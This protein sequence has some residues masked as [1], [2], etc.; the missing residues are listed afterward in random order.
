LRVEEGQRGKPDIGKR[1]DRIM[2]R[3]ARK[4]AGS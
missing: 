3:R 4:Q 2:H 1:P